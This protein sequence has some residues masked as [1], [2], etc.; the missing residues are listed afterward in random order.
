[1][2]PP[3]FS[4][5]NPNTTLRSPPLH[6]RILRQTSTTSQVG[7][8]EVRSGRSWSCG[9]KQ[10]LRCAPNS[11]PPSLLTK[12]HHSH[13]LPSLSTSL[14]PRLHHFYNYICCLSIETSKVK[15]VSNFCNECSWIRLHLLTTY[16]SS[17]HSIIIVTSPP[18]LHSF[19][20]GSSTTQKLFVAYQQIQAR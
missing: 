1:M 15:K 20:R 6:H 5:T 3:F 16:F 8:I 4:P 18:S 13:H 12:L 10:D 14:F 9:Q 19:Y 7:P 2:P 11:T 17:F